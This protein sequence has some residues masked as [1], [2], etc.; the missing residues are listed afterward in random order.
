MIEKAR[1][2]SQTLSISSRSPITYLVSI[3]SL[4]KNSKEQG[5]FGSW[6][7]LAKVREEVF[8]CS[9]SYNKSHSGKMSLDGSQRVLQQSH[10]L[11]RDIFQTHFLLEARSLIS[12]FM[13]LFWVINLWSCTYI[14]MDL[15][16]SR[17]RGIPT[18]S[19]TFQIPSCILPT[20]PSRK[21]QMPTMTSSVAN[22][23]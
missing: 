5:R 21:L 8:S 16:D 6:S 17:M 12:E 20:L 19:M 9:I 13:F 3:A 18:I 10:M 1:F 4:K 15:V 22:G 14:E 2:K 11:Y 7:Q 23:T